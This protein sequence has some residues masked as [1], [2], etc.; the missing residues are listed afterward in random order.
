ML[1]LIVVPLLVLLQC[2]KKVLERGNWNLER[3]PLD[4]M[5]RMANRTPSYVTPS[6]KIWTR[7]HGLGSRGGP[8]PINAPTISFLGT[9]RVMRARVTA[10]RFWHSSHNPFQDMR[11][12][13][14]VL[15]HTVEVEDFD[16]VDG[17]PSG[18]IISSQDTFES[19]DSCVASSCKYAIFV[20]KPRRPVRSRWRCDVIWHDS[21]VRL[22]PFLRPYELLFFFKLLFIIF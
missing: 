15:F 11:V 2:S 7:Y 3:P 1:Q 4:C 12:H 10:N 20:L 19:F 21:P 22:W 5:G 9:C 16:G 8:M 14:A 13:T 17:C 6:R 18:V